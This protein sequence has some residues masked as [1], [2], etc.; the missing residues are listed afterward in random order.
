M[1]MK[2]N[3]Q[4]LKLQVITTPQTDQ[5]ITC[6]HCGESDYRKNGK[7]KSTGTQIYC[8]KACGRQFTPDAANALAPVANPELEYQRDAWD[9]RR[10]GVDVGYEK[11][12]YL[13]NFK[14]I[15]QKWLK[16][17][18][19][20]HLRT[21]LGH[22]A[23]S[24]VQEKAS[25]M[26][27]LSRF[28]AEY[29][30]QI[31]S[32]E[33]NRTVIM[34]LVARLAAEKL[35]P[36]T[37]SKILSDAKLFFEAC[38]QNEWLNVS[39]YLV[40]SED[41][42][43]IPKRI[44]RYIP[45]EV[46]RQLNEHIDELAEPIMRMVLVLQECGMRISE[47]L[48]LKFD[49]LLQDKA[50]DWFLRY[51]QYK[52]RKEITIP[53]SREVVRIIQEQQRFIQESL[54]ESFEFL[55]C[56]N[57][58][59]RRPGF[60]PVPR[61]MSY[62]TIPAY[63]NRLAE[64]HNITDENGVLW[65]FQTHQFRHTVGTRMINNGVPQHIVQR[66]LGHESADMTTVYAHIHDATMKK[67]VAAFHGRVVNVAGQVVEA[68]DIEADDVDL[69]WFKRNLQ[70]QALPNGSCALPTISKGCPHANAC[71][72][73]THFRTTAEYLDIH[74]EELQ[75]T[76]RLLEKARANGWTRQIE[77]NERVE[78]NLVT[79][80]ASLEAKNETEA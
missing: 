35:S 20:L 43:K 51:Y 44:P 6:T 54:T 48:T 55:F 16:D 56:A 70:A 7:N 61:T 75:Q 71:L 72:T 22:L 5:P 36:A 39:R 73:C 77:M 9:A 49:C 24:S 14:P 26:R 50:G 25:S 8:C 29:H 62:K 79:M 32:H 30:P 63:L 18:A 46:M 38:Y 74:R 37:R 21:C 69:Q 11:R 15:T 2:P 31:Q 78:A 42:P 23:F 80:I 17:A 12:S 57:G 66:Y 76:K 65:R 40:R 28:F 52:M 53:I 3:Q 10:L 68:N 58:G 41:F 13:I 19:K 59:A 60:K 64:E 33:I 1:A 45:E 47:L 27:K 34:D 4:Q 67:E